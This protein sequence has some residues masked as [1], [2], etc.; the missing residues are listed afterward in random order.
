MTGPDANGD[1][2]VYKLAEICV[3]VLDEADK[4]PLQVG[5]QMN[6]CA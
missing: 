3:E 1:F 2:L 6:P 4:M 5:C